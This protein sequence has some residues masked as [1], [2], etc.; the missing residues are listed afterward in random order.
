MAYAVFV[1]EKHEKHERVYF[2]V[3]FVGF[4]DKKEMN[5]DL[6]LDLHADFLLQLEGEC[7]FVK[8][9]GEGGMGV[10]GS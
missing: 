2:F 1:H 7:G 6:I 8:A 10:Y 3:L 9:F 5:N 4:V